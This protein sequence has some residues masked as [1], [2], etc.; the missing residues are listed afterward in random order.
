MLEEEAEIGILAL[1]KGLINQEALNDCLSALSDDGGHSLVDL[2]RD[3]NLLKADQIEGLRKE[4][5]K[6]IREWVIGEGP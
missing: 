4:A 1:E 6:R 2:L 5:L 3:K